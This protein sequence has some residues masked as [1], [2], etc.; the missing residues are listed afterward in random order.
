M[1]S[2]TK[3]CRLNGNHASSNSPV[4]LRDVTAEQKQ[5]DKQP[6]IESKHKRVA[7][8]EDTMI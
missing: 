1:I 8:T 3:F 4:H 6:K 5:T 2:F 7:K